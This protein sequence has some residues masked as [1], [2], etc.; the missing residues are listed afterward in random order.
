MAISKEEIKSFIEEVEKLLEKEPTN[1]I[2]IDSLELLK[3]SLTLF[4]K[5][6][7]SYPKYHVSFGR[8]AWQEQNVPFT[9]LKNII[10]NLFY[11]GIIGKPLYSLGGTGY[12]EIIEKSRFVGVIEEMISNVR[13]NLNKPET[14]VKE[15]VKETFRTD[16]INNL[17]KFKKFVERDGFLAFWKKNKVGGNLKDQVEE[18]GKSQLRAFLNGGGVGYV[19]REVPVGKGLQD[20]IYI[21]DLKFPIIIEVKV[22]KTKNK[23][24]YEKGKFQLK[25]YVKKSDYDEGYF[26]I[27]Q[28]DSFYVEDSFEEDIKIHQIV[29]NIAPEAPTKKFKN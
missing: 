1:V 26:V 18:I 24:E 22:F 25:D 13:K 12:F 27:F 23:R 17:K 15:T 29:I 7:A 16:T 2:Y 14:E 5:F 9:R 8:E 20:I 3:I 10:D 4:E 11:N 28:T 6:E 21:K 19:G